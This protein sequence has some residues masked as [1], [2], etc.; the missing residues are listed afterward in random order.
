MDRFTEATGWGLAATWGLVR[1]EN[2]REAVE[3]FAATRRAVAHTQT[4]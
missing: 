1:A 2:Y 4:N 3:S